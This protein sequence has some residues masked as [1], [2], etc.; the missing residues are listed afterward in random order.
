L[1]DAGLWVLKPEFIADFLTV[2]PKPSALNYVIEEV[3]QKDESMNR[4]SSASSGKR[5]AT[6][7]TNLQKDKRVRR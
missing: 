2:Y 7:R 3:Q 6:N 4:G 1:H 5:K